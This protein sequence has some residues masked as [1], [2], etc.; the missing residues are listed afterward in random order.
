MHLKML[1]K[2][3]IFNLTD[4]RWHGVKACRSGRLE[5]KM[6]MGCGQHGYRDFL[7]R[8]SNLAEVPRMTFR[9]IQGDFWKIHIFS[10]RLSN[11]C[12]LVSDSGAQKTGLV[13]F[14]ICT[15]IDKIFE[16]RVVL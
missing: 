10:M 3:A 7:A 13:D 9:V 15:H 14:I 5:G 11:V 16:F 4:L 8:P 6:Q 1:I 2:F 12:T